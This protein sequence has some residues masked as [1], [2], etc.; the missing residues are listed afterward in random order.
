[1]RIML[2]LISVV[3]FI[4]KL[5]LIGWGLYFTI[6][7]LRLLRGIKADLDRRDEQ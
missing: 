3:V 6:A 7:V 2:E 5:A 1:M 4:V